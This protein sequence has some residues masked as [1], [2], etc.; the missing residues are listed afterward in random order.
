MSNEP[1]PGAPK[2][3]SPLDRAL[4]LGLAGRPADALR[5]AAAVL[6]KDLAAPTALH[7]VGRFLADLGRAEAARPALELAVE[8]AIDASRVTLA[9]AAAADLGRVGA[10]PAALRAKI[11]EAFAKGGKRLTEGGH[12]APPKLAAAGEVSPL[13]DSLEGEALDARVDAIVA[14]ARAAFDEDDLARPAPPRLLP[15]P[16]FS[17]LAK[18]G[19]GAVVD[20]LV[21]RTFA[22]GETVIAEDTEGAD[23][24]FVAD[25]RLAVQKKLPDGGNA[26]LASLGEGALFGEMALLARAARAASVVATEPCVLLVASAERLA[27]VARRHPGVAD[28]LAAFC[29]RRMVLNLVRTSPILAVVAQTERGALIER[30]ETRL[31][32]PGALVI[33]QGEEPKGLH[34]IASG[35]VVVSRL[36]GGERTAIASVGVGEVV[37]EMSLVLRRPA[38]ADVVAEP[39]TVTLFL[40]AEK[41]RDAMKAHPELLTRLYDVAATRDDETRTILALEAT[42]ADDF[43]LV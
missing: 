5:L 26:T 8:R 29:R 16:L 20:A 25:G 27:E 40:S 7:L 22:A 33:R 13:A 41:F 4:G 2:G 36:D 12:A 21:P 19:L 11:A 3:G 42:E 37:G 1:K 10:D 14:S 23:T 15:H 17:R 28:E 43:V 38:A 18:D 32:E 30:F 31:Y 6:E 9:I 39:A 34:L 24:F 35:N